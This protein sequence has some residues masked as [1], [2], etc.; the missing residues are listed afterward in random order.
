VKIRNSELSKV[1]AMRFPGS[2][3]ACGSPPG[4]RAPRPLA[5]PARL[6]PLNK[7]GFLVHNQ[8]FIL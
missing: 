3:P 4:L 5:D 7:V 6:K 2:D 1:V 8:R